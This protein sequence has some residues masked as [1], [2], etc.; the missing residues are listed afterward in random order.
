M[1][2]EQ[3][4]NY[5]LLMPPVNDSY[6]LYWNGV[7]VG[8]QGNGPPNPHW[9][10]NPLP[11][12]F[13][14]PS[15]RED[16]IAIRVWKSP[17]LFVDSGTLG[18][19]HGA[20]LLGD[21]DTISAQ[22][23]EQNSESIHQVLYEYTLLILY[24]MV[25]IFS[26]LL[27][28]REHKIRVFLWLALF[29]ATTVALAVLQGLF[30]LP[31]SY[32]LGRGLNQP[33]YALNHVSL[34]LLLLWLLRLNGKRRLVRCTRILAIC[35]LSVALLD[36]F[37]A[38]FWGTAGDWMQ[39]IDAILT[40]LMLAVQ[41]YPILIILMGIRQRLDSAHWAVAIS[42]FISQIINI[43]ADMSAAG[44]RF[45][46]WTL[47]E[48]IINTPLFVIHGI[49]F[50][51]SNVIE[52]VLFVS[53]LY[54]VYRFDTE[55][56]TR[57][58]LLEREMQSA[59]E[60]Q[61]LLIPEAMPS[62]EGYAVTSAYRPALEVGGDFFQIMRRKNGST[63]VALGDVSGKGL[64]AAMTVS[65]IVGILRSL[66]DA[67]YSPAQ[68]LQVLNRC[69]Y[70]RLQ[71]G[72]VTAVI[73]QLHHNGTVT[74]ANAGH[75]PP[76]LNEKELA[77]EGS[78]PLGLSPALTYE[79]SSVHLQQRDQL[80]I[81][82]DGLLEARNTTRELYGFDRLHT[83]FATQPTAQQVTEAAIAFGQNDDITVL[84][85][86]RLAQGEEATTSVTASFAESSVESLI[87][88]P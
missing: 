66:S 71:N 84:T 55:R 44:Q 82:T 27:W 14:V 40:S 28:G 46:H 83:L 22:E 74:I 10:Y 24:G 23:A 62:L 57:Q 70:G 9:F 60:I 45:T 80:S 87:E 1:S 43:I 86:T 3:Q 53:I 37:L 68:I 21:P 30:S 81:Y 12:S 5:A 16:T 15:S 50:W 6:D 75:L 56:Q 61:G 39:T 41:V 17:P 36:G 33:I 52:I 77:T 35:T 26:L 58:S 64:R 20:P 85:F 29:T 59:R 8:H 72:F 79:E 69:L 42:A 19:L 54:A 51:A 34:W 32:G 2:A 47:F 49:A 48:R 18:G 11:Q 38:P 4:G 13:T 31:I 7:L 67:S 25:S 65:L 63:I 76:F 88:L 73:L 78:L